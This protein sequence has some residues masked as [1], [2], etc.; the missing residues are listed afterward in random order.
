MVGE[1]LHC[2]D[3]LAGHVRQELGPLAGSVERRRHHPEVLCVQV[4]EDDEAIAP[5]IDRVLQLLLASVNLQRRRVGVGGGDE[6]RLGTQLARR[7]EDDPLR[8][9]RQADA[10]EEALVELLVDEDVLAPIRAQHVAPDLVRPHLL[11]R[12][13]VEEAGPVG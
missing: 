10:E 12:H 13:R 1:R 8:A 5:V 3:P 9:A 7:L 2:G 4:R 6:P 11:V